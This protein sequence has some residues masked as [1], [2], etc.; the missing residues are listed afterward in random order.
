MIESFVGACAASG[1]GI[2]FGEGFL[3]GGLELGIPAFTG[4]LT[5]GVV[6]GE[7]F[8]NAI[9]KAGISFGGAFFVGGLIEG[10]YATG[11][12]NQLHFND[13]RIAEINEIKAQYALGTRA[14]LARAH[15][16]ERIVAE[17]GIS[18]AT[19]V[20]LGWAAPK[21]TIWDKITFWDG[22]EPI[23]KGWR[24]EYTGLVE[25]TELLV[26]RGGLGGATAKF[27]NVL[28]YN[29]WGSRPWDFREGI[30]VWR[31]FGNKFENTHA[32]IYG[33]SVRYREPFNISPWE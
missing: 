5:H 32:D 29:A 1:A 14:S 17:K 30:R 31:Y 22:G 16:L 21:T 20:K 23:T 3:I 9:K 12:Q 26:M 10:S 4:S 27:Q 25:S 2:T 7:K 6:S 8:S 15:Y 28:T 33:Y 18:A 24:W 11:W 13:T 19:A